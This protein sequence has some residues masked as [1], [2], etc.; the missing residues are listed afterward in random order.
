MNKYS[1]VGPHDYK[2]F[3]LNI[4]HWITN[5]GMPSGERNRSRRDNITTSIIRIS[6]GGGGRGRRGIRVFFFPLRSVVYSLKFK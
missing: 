3:K 2:T 5:I 6:P 1:C 4:K